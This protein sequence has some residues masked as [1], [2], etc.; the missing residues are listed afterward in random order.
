MDKIKSIKDVSSFIKKTESRV[1][2][3]M[4]IE[5]KVNGEWKSLPLEE[6]IAV[7]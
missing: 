2:S 1:N 6:P 5:I 7:F 3:D 4:E